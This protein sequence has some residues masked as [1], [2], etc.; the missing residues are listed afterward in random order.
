MI[1][2]S[3][4]ITE[5]RECRWEFDVLGKRLFDLN[6]DVTE[7]EFPTQEMFAIA[8]RILYV[9]YTV[10]CIIS[11]IQGK[12]ESEGG[13]NFDTTTELMHE[14]YTA[15]DRDNDMPWIL[16]EE[17]VFKSSN[18]AQSFIE[19]YYDILSGVLSYCE[20]GDI[21][22]LQRSFRDIPMREIIEEK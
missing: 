5:L 12:M 8:A 21:S 22:H 19:R 3:D 11:Q 20:E 6:P 14:I 9:R 16:I 17:T 4:Q 10:A 15:F 1:D 18:L 7:E 2:F 13:M